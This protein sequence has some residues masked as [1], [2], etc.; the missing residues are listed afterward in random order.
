MTIVT[1][2]MNAHGDPTALA[3]E[4]ANDR[5]KIRHRNFSA[6]NGGSR[7]EE[8]KVLKTSRLYRN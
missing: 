2:T 1:A 8:I 6:P 7:I 5:K 4:L 3:V